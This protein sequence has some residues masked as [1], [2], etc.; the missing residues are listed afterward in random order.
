ML[1][2]ASL[3]QAVLALI[4]CACL[5]P[6]FNIAAVAALDVDAVK[7]DLTKLFTNSQAFWPADNG[8]YGE[9]LRLGRQY[10]QPG[11]LTRMSGQA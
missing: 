1:A 8:H 4:A 5:P 10:G 2:H 11:C 7:A 3:A 6:Q 9:R